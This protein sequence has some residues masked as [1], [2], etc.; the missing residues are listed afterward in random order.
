MVNSPPNQGYALPPISPLVS[1]GAPILRAAVVDGSPGIH[2]LSN[3]ARSV[4]DQ[5]DLPCCVS[6]ALSSAMEVLDAST[7]SLSPLFHYYVTRYDNGGANSDGF[8]NLDDGLGTLSNN[9]ICSRT[10]HS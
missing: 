4:I 3:K 8:L 7:P 2:E 6:C 1:A 9:G 5:K 10:L